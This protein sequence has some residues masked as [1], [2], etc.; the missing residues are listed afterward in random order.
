MLTNQQ[1]AEIVQDNFRSGSFVNMKSLSHENYLG[2][3][4][5]RAELF[6][7]AQ[8]ENEKYAALEIGV[9]RGDT[10]L[11]WMDLMLQNKTLSPLLTVDVHLCSGY[12][13]Y[14]LE[15]MDILTK[16]A[17]ELSA[18]A[19]RQYLWR[20]YPVLDTT[21]MNGIYPNLPEMFKQY[22]FINLDGPHDEP[23]V[24]V[25]I[26]F[27]YDKL[28]SGGVMVID[29]MALTQPPGNLAK[30]LAEKNGDT[31]EW[32]FNGFTLKKKGMNDV[33]EEKLGFS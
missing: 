26:A 3:I 14:Y 7:K 32:I 31:V 8:E 16:K 25:E 11:L 24:A 15:T 18:F 13:N 19:G 29:D 22:F 21:F 17:K 5:R 23:S 6:F 1:I 33:V 9:F 28:V 27:F 10:S 20:H 4:Q 2:G 30:E 12:Q